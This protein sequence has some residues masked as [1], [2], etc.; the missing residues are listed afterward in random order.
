MSDRFGTGLT[1]LLLHLAQP[2]RDFFTRRIADGSMRD[3]KKQESRHGAEGTMLKVEGRRGRVWLYS[4][5]GVECG[6][7]QLDQLV[8]GSDPFIF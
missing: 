4:V 3:C 6:E 7:T 8:D 2:L 5:V 1:R